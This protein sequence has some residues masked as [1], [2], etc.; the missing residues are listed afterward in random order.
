MKI[1]D[2]SIDRPVFTTMVTLAISVMGFLALGRLGI[3]L[4]PDI[5]F[6]LASVVITY[7]GAGPE[8]VEQQVSRVVEEAVSGINGIDEVRSISRDSV[9]TVIVTF[10]METDVKQAVSDVRDRVAMARGKLPRD[11]L[12]PVIS[13]IDPGAVPVLIYAASSTTRPSMQTRELIDDTVRPVLER[14]DGVG[15]VTLLGGD[16]REIRVE[17]HQDRLDAHR[18]TV[19]QVAQ[20][21]GAESMDI[22]GGRVSV[23]TRELSLKAVARFQSPREVEDVVLIAMPNGTQVR[24]RDVGTVID[25][26]K[27]ARTLTRVN[28]NPSV[29]FQI[30]KQSGT[31]TVATADG[32]EAAMARLQKTLP[33]DITITKVG[34]S[35]RFIRSNVKQLWDALIEGAIFAILVIFLF[36]LDWRSTFISALALPTS[37]VATFFVI[38]QLGF[39]LNIMS[40]LGLSLAIGLLIDD[41][42]VVRENIFRHMERGADPLTAA[43]RG[44]TEIALAVMATT[45]TV[46]AVF[47]PVAF[48]GGIIGRMFRQFGLT[49]AAAVLVSLVVSFT[50]DP[51]MSARL[52]Q[53]IDPHHH[54]KQKKH[55]IYG[56][57]L[58]VLDGM[59]N[60]YRGI[61][62]FALRHRI[63]VVLLAGGAFVGSLSLT[64]LMGTEGFGRG[65]QGQFSVQIELAPGT[66]LTQ[67]D[68]VTRQVEAL[69][70][71][72]PEVIDINTTVGPNEEVSKATVRVKT[73]PKDQ[74]TRSL[75]MIMD[76]LRGQLG[77]VPGLTY[78]LR[79]AG[80]GGE[81]E[82]S[83]MNAPI[84][85]QVRGSDYVELRRI[86]DEV[87]QIVKNTRGTRDIAMSYRP[88]PPEQQLVVDRAKVADL[89]VSFAAAAS[90]LRTAVEGDPV[91]KFRAGDRNIDVRVQLREADRDAVDDILAI[92][93]PTRRGT[94]VTLREVTTLHPS[95]TPATIERINRERLITVTANV[96]NRSLGDVVAE[97]NQGLARL[98]KPS[99]YSF[100]FGG[101][102]ERMQETFSNLGI[103]LL[104]AVLF[105]Y[106][107]LASQFE[108]FIHPFTIMLSL[109]L[110]IV[111]AFAFLFLLDIPLGM[112]AMIGIILLMGLV[113]KN[114][115]LLVDY[116]N[117]LRDQGH[118]IIEALRIAGPT[119]L[120]P[121]LMTSAAMVLGML[122]TALSHSEGSEFRQPMSVAVIGGVVTSTL[123]TLVVV[124]VVYIW[125]DKLTLRHRRE[126]HRAHHNGKPPRRESEVVSDAT[127]A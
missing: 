48:T 43:R 83:A 9:S 45:F 68:R 90:T 22:P 94:P 1:T 86:A 16:V 21:I 20:A 60:V 47:V 117:Q 64:S 81:A 36:M 24:V 74:R 63:L 40:M 56:P 67:T 108:S 101:E 87:H 72:I 58:W 66:S 55:P 44:T 2:V 14:V 51:M 62:D 17:L 124:P 26:V 32:V 23:G 125:F 122:P 91:A 25:G 38:W 115:I 111:G 70:R 126:K 50:L 118:G 79:E 85:L 10:K 37:V 6:P 57:I 76:E 59:D 96:A 35:S 13:R 105:I 99:G 103:A 78:Y 92:G 11:A 121:I 3:D 65:D 69:V 123:L 15:S 54:E 119:R 61:L 107:V 114:G 5:T 109:P 93:V 12:D 127:A 49:V 112:P 18:L 46:V 102:A 88:G 71:K 89:G 7:P 73:T 82:E 27:E 80:L 4:F 31:N 104:L 30:Q 39:T 100:K 77:D 34:D 98:Q 97:I 75:T 29:T 42:V 120:R 116:A 28:G 33:P 19:A 110:A 8:E 84:S 52:T 113:T 53:K 41:S 106:F 95:A